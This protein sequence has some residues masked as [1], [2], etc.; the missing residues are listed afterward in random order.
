MNAFKWKENM[1]KSNFRAFLMFLGLALPL[2]STTT[3]PGPWSFQAT[4]RQLIVGGSML[5]GF[6]FFAGCMYYHKFRCSMGND[7]GAYDQKVS[8]ATVE[9][10]RICALADEKALLLNALPP[11]YEEMATFKNRLT[12]MRSTQKE[13]NSMKPCARCLTIFAWYKQ[14]EDKWSSGFSTKHDALDN[15]K[16]DNEI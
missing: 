3:M 15:L 1:T 16:F 5:F 7:I 8:I 14:H 12:T 6:S 2:S 11:I 13:Q 10:Q 4:P 9:K